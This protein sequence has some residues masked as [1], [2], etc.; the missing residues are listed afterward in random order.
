MNLIDG[1]MLVKKI[2]VEAT[3]LLA[4]VERKLEETCELN[5]VALVNWADYAYKP[6]VCFRIGYSDGFIIL[7]YY[8]EE[9]SVRATVSEINGDVYKDS[10][11]EFFFSTG[12]HGDAYYNFEFN[13]IGVPHVAYGETRHNREHLPKEK[14]KLIKTFSSLGD[15]PFDEKIGAFSW[16]LLIQIPLECLTEDTGINLSQMKSKANFYKCGDETFKP[17]FLSWHPIET[18]QPDFHWSEF[19]GQVHFE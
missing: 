7:K 19:F 5:A 6:A 9:E 14:L 15:Q 4:E 8:V 3:T 18:P 16:E 12:Q 10:C 11:V 1:K 17:H 13:C 2:N